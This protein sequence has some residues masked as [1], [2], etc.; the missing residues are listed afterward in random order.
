MARFR[1]TRAEVKRALDKLAKQRIKGGKELRF[2]YVLD[3][4]K[5]WKVWYPKG[6]GRIGTG[7]VGRIRDKLRVNPQQFEALARCPWR[8]S[9]YDRHI[10]QLRE[11]GEL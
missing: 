4:K 9:H 7:T 10:R 6:R 8:G 5:M 1:Y 2:F 3:G 11:A